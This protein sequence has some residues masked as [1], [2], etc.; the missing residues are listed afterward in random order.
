MESSLEEMQGEYEM[1][2]SEKEKS[3]SV[4][5]Q[6]K[7]L[8]ACITG[9]E[10]LNNKFDPFDLKLDGWAEQVDENIDEYDEIFA[11]LH[12]KYKSKSKIAPEIKLMFQLG[13][14]AIMLH[15]TNSMFRSSMPNMDDVMR[16]NPDLMQQFTQAAVNS[17]G[18]QNPGFSGFMN[19]MMNPNGGGGGGSGPPPGV[20]TG[21]PPMNPASMQHPSMPMRAPSPPSN[22]PDIA[23]GRSLRKSRAAPPAQE[24]ISVNDGFAKV[25]DTEKSRPQKR[26]DMKGPSNLNDIL[27]GLKTKQIN[28]ADNDKDDADS[29][30]SIKELKESQKLMDSQKPKKSKKRPKSEKNVI[31]LDL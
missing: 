7:M 21:P 15:M 13:G 26:P 2:V 16:Q 23:A 3:N 28:I 6:G 9:L 31:S 20:R 11:E 4:K 10:F 8:M 19:N 24:G 25:S 29:T 12:E 5:F 27:S 1:V 18:E 30:I 17:M 14:S 22:R